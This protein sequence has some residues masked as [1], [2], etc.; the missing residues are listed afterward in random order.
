MFITIAL[1]IF[2]LILVLFA[3]WKVIRFGQSLFLFKTGHNPYNRVCRK[4][5]STQSLY[6]S[7]VEGCNSSWWEEE[8]EGTNPNCE[9][10]SFVEKEHHSFI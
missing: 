10:H 8:R 3:I 9:C 2:F 6:Q 1:C 4:C 7:N 5:N